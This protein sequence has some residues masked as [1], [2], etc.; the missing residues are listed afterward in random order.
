M[1]RNHCASKGRH[2]ARGSVRSA[3]R[4]GACAGAC[5]HG[6]REMAKCTEGRHTLL[7]HGEP[8]KSE[9]SCVKKRWQKKEASRPEV[10]LSENANLV[11]LL[12]G[13]V[14]VRGPNRAKIEGWT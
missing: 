2:V 6:V 8:V 12:S 11:S 1:N 3:R 5:T 10:L 14:S 4:R 9:L 7:S 13:A